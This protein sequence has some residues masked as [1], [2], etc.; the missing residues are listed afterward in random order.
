VVTSTAE[1][2]LTDVLGG[3]DEDAGPLSTERP[4]TV[5]SSKCEPYGS[6]GLS[7]AYN[8]AQDRPGGGETDYRG[9]SR[10]RGEVQSGLDVSLPVEWK[11]RISGHGW[12]DAIYRLRGR[13]DYTD[14]LLDEN[15]VETEFDEVWVQGTVS[16]HLDAKLGRQIV[17]WGKSDNI[18]VTDILNPLDR[19]EPGMVDIEDLRLPVGMTRLDCYFGNWDLTGLLVHEVRFSKRPAFGSDF[20]PSSSA[21]AP[22]EEPATTLENTQYAATLSGILGKW[23]VAL[24][25]A[26]VFD[27]RRHLEED[28]ASRQQARSHSRIRMAGAAASVAAGNWLLKT[29]AAYFDGLEYSAD[30]DRP[31]ARYDVLAGVEYR[32]ISDTVVSLEAANRHIVGFD[33]EM[34][35]APDAAREDEFQ[36]ALRLTRNCRHDTLRLRYLLR[37]FGTDG[38]DGGFHRLWAEHAVTDAIRL[39]VGIV[40]YM[41]GDVP[42][43]DTIGDNDR[44]FAECRYSF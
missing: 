31:K 40:D 1:D 22:E 14:E 33:E 7:T 13:D 8:Y 29:E 41:S 16:R 39:T 23:D 6:V 30:P 18:R 38:E 24:Y 26:D 36:A 11:G 19:R 44:A 35:A 17:V 20:L 42:P 3:F 37:L 43:Y 34:G 9:F 32:G 25:V 4:K 2:D 10:L 15:E 28:P 12:Y 27:D 5:G 21:P